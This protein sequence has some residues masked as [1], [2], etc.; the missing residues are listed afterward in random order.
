MSVIFRQKWE[1]ILKKFAI[2]IKK[3]GEEIAIFWSINLSVSSKNETGYKISTRD[4]STNLRKTE[5]LKNLP[6]EK[7]YSKI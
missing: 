3:H 2:K 1:S 4:T 6:I 5:T 7:N